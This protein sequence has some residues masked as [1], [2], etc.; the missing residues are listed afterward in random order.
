MDDVATTNSTGPLSASSWESVSTSSTS[1]TSKSP[2]I[3]PTMPRLLADWQPTA[4]SETSTD[5]ALEEAAAPD[6]AEDRALED[7]LRW[8]G[9]QAALEAFK[10]KHPTLPLN[11]TSDWEQG[12]FHPDFRLMLNVFFWRCCWE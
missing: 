1:L 8:A 2:Q 12:M 4:P 7:S 6:A 3:P 9:L 11:E 5:T 10:A